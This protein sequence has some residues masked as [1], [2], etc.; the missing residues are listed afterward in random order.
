MVYFVKTIFGYGFWSVALFW[1]FKV[2]GYLFLKGLNSYLEN[3][4]RATKYLVGQ[5]HFWLN[6]EAFYQFCKHFWNYSSFQK[7]ESRSYC[8]CWMTLEFDRWYNFDS[9]TACQ[10]ALLAWSVSI[11]FTLRFS[12]KVSRSILLSI[13]KLKN[14]N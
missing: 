10:I 9:F 4:N 2:Q 11:E 1:F 5:W 14:R 6:F 3:Q 13:F 7:R 8:F 12:C